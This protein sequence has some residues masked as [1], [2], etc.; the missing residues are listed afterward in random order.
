MF[1][2]ISPYIL[3]NSLNCSSGIGITGDEGELVEEIVVLKEG[4]EKIERIEEGT[5]EGIE[6]KSEGIK[7][8]GSRVSDFI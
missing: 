2:Y 4:I 1:L 3:I 5:E 7:V 8:G 6:E